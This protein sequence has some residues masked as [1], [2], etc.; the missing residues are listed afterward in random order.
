MTYLL[1]T[2]TLIWTITEPAKLSAKVRQIIELPDER[3]LVSALTFW[4]ISLKYALGK[5]ILEGVAP[6]DFLEA[7]KQ[8]DIELLP[9]TAEIG[10]TFHKLGV[11]YHKDPF[12]RMLAWQA[13]EL[14]IPI[15]S[16]DE[17][18]KKYESIGIA[19]IW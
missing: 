15:L 4:E 11:F 3:I 13:K 1:D 5:L 8:L 19:V 9:L 17:E 12:D 14:G 6:E 18:L 16:R 10:A 7:C 2:H